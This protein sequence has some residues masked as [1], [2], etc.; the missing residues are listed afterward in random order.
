M[1]E[2]YFD[3]LVSISSVN[4]D[5]QLEIEWTNLP[6]P[7]GLGANESK[8]VCFKPLAGILNQSKLLPLKVAP[9]T[10]E[11]ELVGTP[12]EAVANGITGLG[13]N[14][15]FNV[16]NVSKAWSL[17]DVQMKCDLLTLDTGLDNEYTQHLL[18]GKALS[19]N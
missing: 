5:G 15:V 3:P 2:A 14:D 10:F 9:L 11:F 18:Q 19:I 1:E 17:S 16:N 8:I 13:A 12:E 7:I 4:T 6:N